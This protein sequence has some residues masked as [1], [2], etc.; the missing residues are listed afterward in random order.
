MTG[1]CK[2]H[3]YNMKEIIDSGKGNFKAVPLAGA[4]GDSEVL[5]TLSTFLPVIVMLFTQWT[6]EEGSTVYHSFSVVINLAV[7]RI[8]CPKYN[9]QQIPMILIGSL[10]MSHFLCIL[11]CLFPIR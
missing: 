3:P 6:C 5:P 4:A 2:A 8:I 9:V 10:P 1:Y 7:R 11:R